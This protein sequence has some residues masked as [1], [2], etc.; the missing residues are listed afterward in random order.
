MFVFGFVKSFADIKDIEEDKKDNIM[1][2]PSKYGEN[3][4]YLV[5]GL[6]VTLSLYVHT[7]E[8][9]MDGG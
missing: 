4:T 5:S 2:I 8:S 7:Q 9:N 6:L 3:V 1:T